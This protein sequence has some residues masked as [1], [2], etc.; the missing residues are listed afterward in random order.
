MI[1]NFGGRISK[2]TTKESRTNIIKIIIYW[3]AIMQFKVKFNMGISVIT[4]IA[5]AN[6]IITENKK[7]A[8]YP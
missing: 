5:A 6:E 2:V 4:Y 3:E 8:E 1:K 7:H